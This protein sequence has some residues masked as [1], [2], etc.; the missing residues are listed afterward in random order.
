LRRRRKIA[1]EAK[2]T[3]AMCVNTCHISS[4][5]PVILQPEKYYAIRKG[6]NQAFFGDFCE[7]RRG[8]ICDHFRRG[9]SRSELRIVYCI[10]CIDGV[11]NS[12]AKWLLLWR[13]CAGVGGDFRYL[14]GC[15]ERVLSSFLQFR[16][17]F[18]RFFAVFG[19]FWSGFEPEKGVWFAKMGKMCGVQRR[20]SGFEWGLVSVGYG[21]VGKGKRQKGKVKSKKVQSKYRRSRREAVRIGFV[22]SGAG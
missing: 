7:G 2:E 11:G 13:F 4:S 22:C 12:C 18:G 10:L 1:V 5:I 21:F 20:A 8:A 17:G 9:V 6:G 3:N 19:R 14:R 16:T 15:F